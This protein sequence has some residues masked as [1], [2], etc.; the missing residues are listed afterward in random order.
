[1]K[2]QTMIWLA[3]VGIL[4]LL[5]PSP[6][7]AGE[8]TEEIRSA[9]YKGL[10]VLNDESLRANGKNEHMKRLREI[11]RPLFNFKEM[12]RRSLGRHWRDMTPEDR[13]EFVTVF[14]NLL[15]TTYAEKIDLYRGG[16]VNFVREVVDE[17]Y[18]RVDSKVKDTKGTDY[19]VSYKL[20]REDGDWKIY[21]VVVENVSL[22]N[23]YRAQFGR[24]IRKSSFKELVERIKQKSG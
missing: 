13:T 7:R 1:M 17:D 8:P 2:H 16:D 21:D 22:I 3:L 18:A 5:P 20:L 12:A 11:V 14:A 9:I 6:I 4:F 10:A 15:E 19:S 23:N 24:I